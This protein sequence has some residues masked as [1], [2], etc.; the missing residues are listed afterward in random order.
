MQQQNLRYGIFPVYKEKGKTSFEVVREIRR[1]TGEKKV[2]HA[3]T[4]DPLAKGILVIGVGRTATKNLSL[5]VSE[6][7]EYIAKIK[8]G[9]RSTTD[10]REGKKEKVQ[11]KKIPSRKDILE[12]L[13][14]FIG[15]IY[16]KPPQFSAKKVSGI[17]AY[18]IARAGKQVQLSSQKVY[19]KRIDL[20]KYSWPYVVLRIIC[21]P[22]TYIRSLARDIGEKLGTGAYVYDLERTRI[23]NFDKKS[24]LSIQKFKKLW[25]KD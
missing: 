21:G 6:E 18:Q 5:F 14:L 20:I 16:Q 23:G 15:Y 12:T 24:A 13:K 19:I 25:K 10:D 17:R 3:G 9:W 8:L 4:L 22:G 7:K 2:G 11:V 1:I